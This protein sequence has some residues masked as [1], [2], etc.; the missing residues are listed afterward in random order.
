MGDKVHLIMHASDDAIIRV[1]RLYQ[2][3]SWADET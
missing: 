1:L 2:T 3:E